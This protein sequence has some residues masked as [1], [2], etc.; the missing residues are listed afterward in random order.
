MKNHASRHN[1]LQGLIASA[2]IVG[3]D[4]DNHSWVT[5]ANAAHSFIS[6][7]HLDGV[8]YTDDATLA[9]IRLIEAESHARVF[10][11][12][13]DDLTTFTHDQRLLIEDE[14]FNYVEGQ[15]IS[16]PNGGWRYLLETASFYTPPHEPD[17]ISLLASLSYTQEYGHGFAQSLSYRR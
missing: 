3:F 2:V 5:A 9:T 7:P 12:D 15:I 11:L 8:L 10:L 1:I 13:Y 4:T 14:R 6:L 16:G 17:N